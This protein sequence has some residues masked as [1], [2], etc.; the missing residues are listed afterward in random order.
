MLAP[1][2]QGETIERPY[3]RAMNSAAPASEQA[4]RLAPWSVVAA[5][6]LF[7]TTGTSAALGPDGLSSI[8]TGAWRSVIGGAVLVLA[9]AVAGQAPWRYRLRLW[10]LVAGGAA[11][12]AY[13]L[14]FFAAVERTG[15]AVGTVVTIGIG[16]VSAM[17]LDRFVMHHRIR[18]AVVA[19]AGIAVAGVT[20]LSLAGSTTVVPAGVGLAVLAGAAYPVY[21]LAT[22]RLMTDRPAVTAIATIFGA[23]A[24]AM[25][26][27]AIATTRPEDVTA[28]AVVLWVYLG[29]ATLAAAYALWAYG[30]RHLTLSLT[31]TI[32]LVEPAVATLL[33]VALLDERLTIPAVIGMALIVTGVVVASMASRR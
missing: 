25:L 31:V 6:A 16:P 18:G 32:T 20:L 22:Q 29:V 17:L 24:A 21:G 2:P 8:V 4:S 13:Q 12:A 33:A 14:F 23:G 3:S 30:L 1:S 7:G 10:P 28:G 26:P 5:A 19:G 27:V 15:V 11:V 9:V